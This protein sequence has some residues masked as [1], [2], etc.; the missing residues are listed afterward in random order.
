MRA[1]VDWLYEEAAERSR[2]HDLR[3]LHGL[4]GFWAPLLDTIRTWFII[5][6]TGVG[7]GVIGAWLGV[8]V[9]WWVCEHVISP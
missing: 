2:Q 7:V 1:Y 6:A 4:R 5:I 9:Q 3:A 8:L